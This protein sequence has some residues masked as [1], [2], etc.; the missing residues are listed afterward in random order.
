MILHR[1]SPTGL[2]VTSINQPDGEAIPL[3][4]TFLPPPDLTPNV[5]PYA[6]FRN[7]TWHLEDTKPTAFVYSSLP[8]GVILEAFQAKAVLAQYGLLSTVQAL[9]N[10]PS[11]PIKARLAWDNAV[12]FRRDNP[13]VLLIAEQLSLS[14]EI[15]DELFSVGATITT[16]TI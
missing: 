3:L 15:L 11:T 1:Y 10:N 5:A 12:P 9:I 4:S 7:G 14:V 16:E 8:E 6:V 13:L 2:Y